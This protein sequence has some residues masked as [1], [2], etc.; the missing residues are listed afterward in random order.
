MTVREASEKCEILK[1][2]SPASK[3]KIISYGML[4]KYRKNETIFRERETVESIFFV[5]DGYVALSKMNRNHDHKVVFVYGAG[6]LL[7]E[8]ILEKNI[9]S[10]T[11]YALGDVTVLA[12]PRKHFLEIMEEDFLFTRMILNSLAIKTRRLYHQLGNTSNAMVLEKQVASKLWKLGR[13][14]GVRED[15]AIR[16]DFDMT[17]TFL[18]D[19]VG[20]KR[21]TVSRVLKKL[22]ELELISMKKNHFRIYDMDRL[23]EFVAEEK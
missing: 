17:I 12:F 9:A 19:M 3:A 5:V 21:E 20:S 4:R 7:N 11:G 14:F 2:A 23:K 13:D 1:S 22:T 18:A 8:V 6:V 16:I 10:I 15:A